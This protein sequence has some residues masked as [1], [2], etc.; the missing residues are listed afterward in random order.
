MRRGVAVHAMAATIA[1]TTKSTVVPLSRLRVRR[2]R[3]SG[4]SRVSL[5]PLAQ[6]DRLQLYGADSD[7]SCSV[8]RKATPTLLLNMGREGHVD[9]NVQHLQPV[10]RYMIPG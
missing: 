9:E 2:Q 8:H 3:A 5:S 4:P 6:V 10:Q 7:D 1:S